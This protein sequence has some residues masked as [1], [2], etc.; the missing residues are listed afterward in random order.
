MERQDSY[1]IGI[2]G[3]GTKSMLLATNLEGKVIGKVD[4]GATNLHSASQEQVSSNLDGAVQR[5]LLESGCSMEGCRGVC[6][7]AAGID[8]DLNQ[9]KM[10]FCLTNLGFSCDVLATSDADIALKAAVKDDCGMLLIAGTGSIALAK[11]E[12]GEVYR[13]GGWDYLLG[14]E[15]S[16]YWIAVKAIQRALESWDETGVPSV[17]FQR[18]IEEM[19]NRGIDGI[20]EFMYQAPFEKQRIA[21]I[22][23][24]VCELDETGDSDARVIVLQAA[25]A[26]CKLATTLVRRMEWEDK[27]FVL[28]P[29]GSIVTKNK[30]ISQIFS[31]EI[32]SLYPKVEV[33]QLQKEASFGAVQYALELMR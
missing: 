26:L 25:D 18:M 9:Q 13:A 27:E 5:F 16:G 2:E 24:I 33:R 28:V 30:R 31:E 6:I 1:V 32:R 10:E 7:G 21:K 3:G 4:F 19:G 17:L 29:H 15:G 23:E 11:N 22:A 20:M 8:T 14:D 12:V